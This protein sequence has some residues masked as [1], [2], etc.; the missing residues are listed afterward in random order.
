MKNKFL[1]LALLALWQTVSAS[2]GAV[3]SE[4]VAFEDV[5]KAMSEAGYIESGL[6]MGSTD[7]KNRLAFWSVDDGVLIVIYSSETKKVISVSYWLSDERPKATRQTFEM[8]V[9]SF[10]TDSGVMTIQTKALKK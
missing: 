2:L 4:G 8:A 10:D 5:N 9:K 7:P 1:F 3:V 6:D